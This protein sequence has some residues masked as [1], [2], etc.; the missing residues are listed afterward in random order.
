MKDPSLTA[1]DLVESDFS[2]GRLQFAKNDRASCARCPARSITGS[3]TGTRSCSRRRASPT[4]DV[5]GDGEPAEALTDP[6]EGIYGFVARGLRT[7]TCRVWTSFLLGYG[8]DSST[9]RATPDRRA[10]GDR[11][12]EALSAPADE[13]RPAGR[14]RLQLEGVPGRLHAGHVGDVARRRRLRA[15]ARGPEQVARRRQ[16]RLRRDAE[17]AEGAGLGH[18][19]RRHRRSAASKK[20]EAAYLYCQWA[21]S[22]AMGARLLQAGAGVPFRASILNDEASAEASRCRPHGCN[23]SSESAKIRKPACR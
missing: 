23:R 8:G 10:G 2:P 9:R 14:R 19:R 12:G 16:G 6:K 22:K 7:P 21:V 15:A 11:G 17:G 18:V 3:S 13:V 5:R 4:R 20:K 1:P